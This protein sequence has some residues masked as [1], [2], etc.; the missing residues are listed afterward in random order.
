MKDDGKHL[1]LRDAV[2][3]STAD[4]RWSA[5]LKAVG[6]NDDDA[7][8][9]LSGRMVGRLALDL[10][11]ISKTVGAARERDRVRAF[12]TLRQ[13]IIYHFE[14]LRH[15]SLVL[16]G[17]TEASP[18]KAVTISPDLP[19]DY[20][21]ASHSARCGDIRFYGITVSKRGQEVGTGARK[22]SAHVADTDLEAF[23]R[24]YLEGKPRP[25]MDELWRAAEQEF[26]GKRVARDRVRN[27][28]RTL[29]SAHLRKPGPRK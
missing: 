1:S 2:R 17:Y 23:C 8:N 20:D 15:G 11:I 3:A 4:D 22:Q 29:I 9:A 28:H 21:F 7:I 18:A 13:E 5:L 27:L 12:E 24:R 19:L 6:G 10:E 14:A 25:S 26:P 16:K